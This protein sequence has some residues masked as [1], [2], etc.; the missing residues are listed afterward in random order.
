MEHQITQLKNQ[1]KELA[2]QITNLRW[3]QA[4]E[5]FIGPSLG[6]LIF[7]KFLCPIL[8][9]M[10]YEVLCDDIIIIIKATGL[11][12]DKEDLTN[13]KFSEHYIPE[14][15]FSNDFTDASGD[16]YPIIADGCLSIFTGQMTDL[17]FISEIYYH[18]ERVRYDSLSLSASYLLEKL[19]AKQ[20]RNDLFIN[21]EDIEDRD[22]PITTTTKY[23]TSA[24]LVRRK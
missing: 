17:D 1:R 3:Q 2:T 18:N 9:T 13:I 21:L 4:L 24:I 22:V 8:V 6:L 20:Y 7:P 5:Q 11:V 19:M 12:C 14:V 23:T 16:H 15:R 10:G